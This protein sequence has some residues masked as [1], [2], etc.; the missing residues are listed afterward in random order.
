MTRHPIRTVSAAL[1]AGALAAAPVSADTWPP[2]QITIVI[3]HG[4]S[5]SQNQTTRVL[6]EVWGEILGTQFIYDNRSGAS[7]RVGYDHFINQP[8]D[9]SYLLSSNVGSA[10]IMYAQQEPDW[11]WESEII[12]VGNFAIDPGAYFARRDRGWE[13]FAD[14]L[15]EAQERRLTVG[16]SFWASPENLQLHQ[17]M[18]ATGVEFEI[19]PI[20]ESGELV[21][22]TLGGHVDVGY[23]K[24]AVAAR[25]GD[26]LMFLGIAMPTNPVPGVTNDAPAIDEIIGVETLGVASFRNILAHKEW[27]DANPEHFQRLVDTLDEAVSDPRFI[28]QMENLETPADLI[29]NMSPD[30]V[31][32]EIRRSWAAFEAFGHIYDEG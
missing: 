14:V 29:V 27:A 9:G 7:G 13:T 21:T 5:S 1:V 11:D 15:E 19:I 24:V 32:S 26:E 3:S 18:E 31:T 20:G 2:D 22:A 8:S 4:V 23:N 16:I 28:Q 17:V 12:P 25:G 6:G 10:S 30:E